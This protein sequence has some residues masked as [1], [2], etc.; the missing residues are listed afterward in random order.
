M[1]LLGHRPSKLRHNIEACVPSKMTSLL[2]IASLFRTRATNPPARASDAHS[3][4][5][6][7]ARKTAG[8]AI[9]GMNGT[10]STPGESAPLAFTGGLQRSACPVA[11]GRRI[12][13]GTRNE[14]LIPRS[15]A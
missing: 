2:W 6:R 5:G 13:T 7:R 4:V 15:G 12:L 9:V 8:P 10:R 1:G 11:A 14:L 3:A